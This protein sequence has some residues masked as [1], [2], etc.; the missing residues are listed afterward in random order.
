MPHQGRPVATK[1]FS[2]TAALLCSIAD[3]LSGDKLLSAKVGL[4]G[5]VGSGMEEQHDDAD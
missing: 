4:D 5:N 1:I 3:H 2:Q